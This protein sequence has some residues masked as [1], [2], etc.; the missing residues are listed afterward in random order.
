MASLE[1]L[2]SIIGDVI[3]PAAV[4]T[5]EKAVFPRAAM[6]ALGQAGFLGLMSAKEFGG[7]GLG[8]GEA[9]LVVE[10]IARVCPSTAMVLTMHY[11]GAAILEKWGAE[12]IRR[13]IA[14]GQHL[15]T[16]AWSEVGSRSHFWAPVGTARRE[17][18]DFIL[19]G[20]KSMVTSALEADSYIWTSK[21]AEATGAATLWLVERN[22]SGLSSPHT[23]QGLGLRGNASAP[24]EGQGMKVSRA[25]M[26]GADGSGFDTMINLVLPIFCTL[27]ASGSLGIMDAVLAASIEHISGNKFEHLNTTLSDLPTIRAYVARARIRTDQV[28]TLRDDT[29]V[30]LEKNRADAMLRVM[31]VKA[32]AAEEALQVT[33]TA[34]RVCGGAAFRKD[35]GIERFFRDARASSI[36][37]PTSDVLYDFIGKAI[38]NLPVFA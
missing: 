20:H 10:T 21:P 2:Q 14:Q 25:A 12:S 7:K 13:K 30:A 15:T 4:S 18:N 38:C 11:C 16:L 36:M 22:Q 35:V 8:L 1:S 32:A 23:F 31:E 5:D 17:G 27:C 9:A 28:R 37:A 33:D 29:L 6:T 26:L 19:N 24:L 34:L 3:A